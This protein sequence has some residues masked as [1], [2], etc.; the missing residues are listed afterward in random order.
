MSVVAKIFQWA[1]FSGLIIL[2]GWGAYFGVSES[3][4]YFTRSEDKAQTA[5]QGIFLKICEE[6]GLDPHSFHGPHRNSLEQDKKRGQYTFVWSRNQNEEIY[7][8]VSYLPYDF[9]YSS[10]ETLIGHRTISIK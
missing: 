9:A 3:Y 2:L 7:V 6:D 1:M 8:N 5:A 10:S 4:I